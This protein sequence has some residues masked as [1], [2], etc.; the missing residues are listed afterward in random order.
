MDNKK[1]FVSFL[2]VVLI[3][4]SLSAVSAADA[5]D[6]LSANQTYQPEANTVEAVQSAIDLANET[7]TIDISNY[8][9]YDFGNSSVSITKDN[10]VFKGNG[11]T[12]IKGHGANDAGKGN[13]LIEVSAS[14]VT[15]QG[16]TF[17][18]T[19]PA[20]DFKYNGTVFGAAVRFMAVTGGSLSDCTFNNFSSAAVV[21]KSTGVVLENNDVKGGYT[22]IIANDPT[23]NVEKGTKAFNIYG[24]SSAITVRGNTFEGQQLDGISIAQGSGA[25]IVENNTFI[26]NT[27]GIYF[28]GSS[29]K[30]SVIRNNKF[31]NCGYFLEGEVEWKELPVISIQKASN[32][33]AIEDNTF[34][35]V[36]NSILIAAEQGN[37]AHGFPS[38]LG[39]INVT[40][41]TVTL[42]DEAAD[43][44]TV[45]LFHVLCRDNSTLNLFAPLKVEDNNL[46]DGVREF[47]VW[48]AVWGE[49]TDVLVPN[50]NTV[51]DLQAII[52]SAMPGDVIDISYYESFDFANASVSINKEGLTLKANGNTTISGHGANDAGKGNA[53]VEISASNVT[54]EGIKFVDTHPANDF[55]YNGTVFGAAVRFMAATGGLLSN[56][57][58]E[59][60]SSAA[61]VQKSTGIVLENNYISGGYTTIIANDPTVNVEKGTKAFNIYGQSSAI[62]VRGNTFE[63]QQL[64]GVSIAQGSGANIVE[65]NIFM[66]NTYGIYFGGSSTKNSVIRNN[67]FI[68]CGYFEEGDV[69]WTELPVISI[70]KASNDIAIEDNYFEALENSILIAAEQGNEAHGFPSSLG[71]INVTGNTVVLFNKSAD[72]TTV[73]LFHVLC[74]DN[75]TLNLFAPLIV[76]NNTLT[77]GVKE[78]VVVSTVLAGNSSA[79]LQALIDAAKPGDVIDIS[80]FDK[81]DFNDTNIVIDKEGLTLKGN[82]NTTIYGHGANDAGK[83]NA[84]I[85]I[86]ASN[87]TVEGIK[88]VDT[89]PLNNFTYNGT[90]YGAA[91]R[92]MGVTGGLLTNCTFEDFSSAAIVQK[93]TGVVLENNY[94]N[95]GYTTVIANDPTVNIEKGS[96]S[97]NIY[98]QSSA[99]TVR[100]NTFEGQLL[101]GVSIAQGS[102][103]NIVEDNIFVGNTYGIYFGG[104]STKNSVI[105]NNTFIGCGY[106]A[107]GEV[108]WRQLPVI[109]IQKASNDI[110]ITD[111]TFYA[112]DDNVLIAAEQGNEAHGFPSSLGNINVTGNKV[113]SYFKDP[114]ARNVILFS[115]LCRN[116]DLNLSAPINV[117]GN[118]VED[119]MKTIAIENVGDVYLKEDNGT[120]PEPQPVV[121]ND[122]IIVVDAT[123]TRVANDYNAGERGGFFYAVLQDANGNPLVNKTVQIALNGPIYNVT[124]DEQ[125]RAGLQVNLG[126]ANTYTYALAFQGD[127]NY[128]AA[129][130]ASSKLTLTKKTTSITAS[131]K[132]FKANAKTKSVS[133]TLKTSKNQFD[134]KTYLKAGKK[135]TL[136]VNGKTYSAKTNANGVAKFSLKLTK[137]GKYTAKISF[138]GDNTYAASSKSIK[139]TIK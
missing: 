55:K 92:F 123:F 6:V 66:G 19:H 35:A 25:N 52:D 61:I 40:G 30:N 17:I 67:T 65:N 100:G 133:V 53:L 11:N 115:I 104:S 139:I 1:I 46:T 39:N 110:A 91:V 135:I 68:A 136:K 80:I 107:E 28:G 105:R 24:Q 62:T 120:T 137:K 21:Q 119:G 79:D 70:Q 90:V 134:G 97:F 73:T 27:Y 5:G 72:P 126:S 74:R 7:D 23:V 57:T 85:E 108:E 127:D 114:T 34:V 128:N 50:N 33:I 96:K 47:K 56:C 130:L 10:V 138:A 121:K 51:E 37:E 75:T 112:I 118:V 22:T 82:G 84:L 99:I 48:A 106:F 89:H 13:A 125:G 129:P 26:G 29:T 16:I 111:N 42:V 113:I 103:A 64:D 63:G 94:I 12:I 20:N 4:V 88:F 49:E 69:I 132:A 18:D 3:A 38:S 14:N 44:K 122:T 36:E 60:F 41:N 77:E 86:T 98:G 131:N 124:T 8:A 109:S 93:S 43:A 58:F 15:I 83:G 101:D 9:E 102:G 87:V 32:D 54:V 45:T 59:N 117:T 76:E 95:G 78:Y 31:I 2:L 116:G 71:N 81:F